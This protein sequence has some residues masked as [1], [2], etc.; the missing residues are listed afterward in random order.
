MNQSE[1]NSFKLSDAVAF[2]DRLNP[3]LFNGQ[4][5]KSDVE[6]QLKIIAQDFLEEMGINDLDVTDITVSGS[7]AAYSYTKHSDLD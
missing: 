7:N 4:H 2:H 3:K 1:L 5:L 6:N